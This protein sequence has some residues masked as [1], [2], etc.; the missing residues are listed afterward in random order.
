M[1][2]IIRP[3]PL[4]GA[5][6]EGAVRVYTDAFS[7]PPYSEPSR[8][9]NVRTR[10]QTVHGMRPGFRAY[11]AVLPGHDVIGMAYGYHGTRG[12]Y[13]HDLVY[14][15]CSPE[16]RDTWLRD[17]YEIVELAVDPGY[18]GRGIGRRLVETLLFEREESTAVLST[19]IDSTAPH[20]YRSLG[21][22]PFHEMHFTDGGALFAVMGKA[23]R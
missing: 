7:A 23:L 21:F 19:R 22:V 10:L 9:N 17:C 4:N 12:Q 15:A 13:W 8:G 6:F 5:L 20:L 1:S 18:Q 11:C 16:S 14:G 2:W 3:L